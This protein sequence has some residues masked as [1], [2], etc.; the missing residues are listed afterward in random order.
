MVLLPGKY[1]YNGRPR[2][3]EYVIRMIWI[4]RMS[5]IDSLMGCWRHIG[6][7]ACGLLQ[8]LPGLASR[9]SQPADQCGR[10]DCISLLLSIL[11][12]TKNH[13]NNIR[14]KNLPYNSRQSGV[15]TSVADKAFRPP[16]R[17]FKMKSSASSAGRPGRW[18]SGSLNIL[19]KNADIFLKFRF[20]CVDAIRR[21]RIARYGQHYQ[22]EL[23]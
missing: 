5:K 18:N 17:P 16:V 14:C 4:I 22:W 21:H 23:I 20:G 19:S 11:N 7:K 10:W 9:W 1:A 13:R 6:R 3:I 8:V 15:K 2:K 12:C